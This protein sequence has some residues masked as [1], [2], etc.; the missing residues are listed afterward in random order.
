LQ[1]SIATGGLADER[2]GK[3]LKEIEC[4]L[5]DRLANVLL[6]LNGS[7]SLS[8]LSVWFVEL[9]LYDQPNGASRRLK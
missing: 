7:A 1:S 8:G 2:D 3:E 9:L 5:V 4:G 6:Y